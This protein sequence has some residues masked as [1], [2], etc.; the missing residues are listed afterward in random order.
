MRGEQEPQVSMLAF[1]D[2]ESRIPQDHPLRTIRRFADTALSELSPTF[3]AMYAKDGR[4]SIPPERLLK[5]SLLISLYSVRSERAFCEQLTYNELFRWFLGMNLIEPSFDPSTFSKNRQRLLDHNVA[6]RFF[7]EIVG[8]ADQ[9]GLLSDDHF[10]VDGTLIEAAAS[11][12]S[13]RPKDEPPSDQPPDDPGNPTVNFHG[14]KRSNATHQSTT[15]PDAR[16][17]RTGKGKEAKLVYV[18]QVLMENRNGMA[19][20]F[21]VCEATGTAERDT[22]L[23]QVDASKQRGFRPKTVG[24][25]KNYDTRKF[26]ADLRVRNVTPHVAQ[27]TSGR[28]SAMVSDTA[29]VGQGRAGTTRSRSHS[30]PP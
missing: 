3:D 19:I 22:A 18:G 15:D 28:R 30:L 11:L 14:Q 9:L 29:S 24:G 21:S 6:Q 12:K 27:N 10:T 20:D 4:A 7:D 5:A 17:F 25:D 2:L 13:F 8:A 1:I 26:V 16:L 23:D